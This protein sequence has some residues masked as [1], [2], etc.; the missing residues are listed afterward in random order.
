MLH[1]HMQAVSCSCLHGHTQTMSCSHLHGNTEAVKCLS[2]HGHTQAMKCSCFIVTHKL[3]IL[4]CTLR[5]STHICLV[6]KMMSMM[7]ILYVVYKPVIFCT[8]H[9]P[10]WK[11]KRNL[12]SS[13]LMS[14]WTRIRMKI[15]RLFT[16][17]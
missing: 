1:G 13:E 3:L 12:C 14:L 8:Y 17:C 2:L 9:I 10:L 4:V 7:S 11:G 5:N 6:S 16:K 15:R